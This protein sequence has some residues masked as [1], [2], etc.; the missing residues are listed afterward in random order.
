MSGPSKGIEKADVQ[1]KWDPSPS[2]AAAH[3]LDIIAATYRADDPHG[4]PVY[5]VHF[6]SRSP[7]G[8][9]TLSRDSTTG[10]GFGFDEI[11]SFEFERLA[12]SYGRVVVG[13]VIQQRGGRTTF[14]DVAGTRVRVV[15]GYIELAEDDFASVAGAT[16]A[17]VAEFA[18]DGSAGWAF[19]K[20]V[21]GFDVSGPEEFSRVMGAPPA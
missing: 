15:E 17:T 18:R 10:Q 13:V 6:D 20:D 11:M 7:D 21:R 9:I 19:R 14:G 16:A 8:T 1:I 12:E 3:D 2:G 4:A 5:L